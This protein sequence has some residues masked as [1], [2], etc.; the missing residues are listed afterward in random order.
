LRLVSETGLDELFVPVANKLGVAVD[1]RESKT[2]DLSEEKLSFGYVR[3]LDK[4]PEVDH[5]VKDCTD[6][7]G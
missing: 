6:C 2:D 1:R 3:P 7:E 5:E 4:L